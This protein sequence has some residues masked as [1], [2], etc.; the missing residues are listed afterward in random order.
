MDAELFSRTNW[1]RSQ[2][3][4]SQSSTQCC[5]HSKSTF[6]EHAVAKFDRLSKAG[7]PL[8]SRW[9]TYLVM[10]SSRMQAA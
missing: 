9:I 7:P 6:V 2:Y 4:K 3:K 1:R 5:N 10:P 8:A